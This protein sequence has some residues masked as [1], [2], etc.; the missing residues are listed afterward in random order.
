MIEVAMK[1]LCGTHLVVDVS[2]A[3]TT[4]DGWSCHCPDC[5]DPSPVSYEEGPG[6]RS[7][8]LAYG[9]TP[10]AAVAACWAMIEEAWEVEYLPNNT[11]ERDVWLQ[12]AEERERTKGWKTRPSW[13]Q[14]E[15]DVWFGPDLISFLQTA[16]ALA[17][18]RESE[19]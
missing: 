16:N 3:F 18:P 8:C 9:K 10:E 15:K 11:L 7:T 1:C 4:S 12:I 2:A 13:L 14:P 5:Y 19:P 17:T 6:P